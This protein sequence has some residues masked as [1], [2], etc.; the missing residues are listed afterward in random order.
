MWRAFETL[1]GGLP[2]SVEEKHAARKL[3]T[4]PLRLAG[5]GL[6]FAERTAPAAYW[7]S[8]ADAFAVVDARA[9]QVAAAALADL[10]SPVS[11]SSCLAE[12]RTA[13]RLLERQGFVERPTW[14]DLV[15]G[16][17]PPEKEKAE[18]GEWNHG[19]QYFASSI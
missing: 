4:L 7:A 9:P 5:L 16:K 14:V 13:T 15:A 6:R 19:W 11:N 10:E 2:G 17:R 8:W 3:A 1:W 12:L 18:P